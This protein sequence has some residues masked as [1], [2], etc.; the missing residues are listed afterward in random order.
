MMYTSV[1][2]QKGQTTIP[3][4]IR[5]KLGLTKGKR[6]VFVEENDFVFLKSAVNF[7]DLKG[8]IKTSKKYSDEKAD[9]AVSKYIAAQ[10]E[11]KRSHS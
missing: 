6:V 8:S 9:K 1:I 5:N 2:T 10:Y 3:I 4:R 11:K 7:M